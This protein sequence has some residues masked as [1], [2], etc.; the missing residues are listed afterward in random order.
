MVKRV[1]GSLSGAH[2]PCNAE[3]LVSCSYVVMILAPSKTT[4]IAIGANARAGTSGNLEA[5]RDAIAQVGALGKVRA[6]SGL[7]RNPAWPPG[8][9][10][11]FVN[12]CLALESG[13][14]PEDVMAGL[15]AIEAA[16]GRKRLRR[17]G[18]RVIDLDLLACADRILPDRATLDRWMNLP[19]GLQ[20]QEAPDRLILPHPRLHERAFVLL[21]LAEI[22]PDWRHPVLGWSV[23]EM[24]AGL[25]P[26]AR[27][28]MQR[29]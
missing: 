2:N 5:V 24:A 25:D 29:L 16:M 23:A 28:G 15:H 7:W 27:E 22:A 26:S 1:V 19:P 14:A 12:A 13:H 20:A 6:V 17:W 4:L 11:D 21:P 18:P 3:H 9:G 8:S 10:P